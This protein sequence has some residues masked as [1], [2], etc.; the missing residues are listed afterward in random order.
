MK[1]PSCA[2]VLRPELLLP[3]VVLSALQLSATPPVSGPVSQAWAVRI[4]APTN[5][6]LQGGGTTDVSPS[7]DAFVA[8]YVRRTDSTFDIVISRRSPGGILLW[9]RQYEPPDG[10]SSDE[11][12]FGI[13]AHG[14][15]V[16]LTGSIT[17]PT[18]NGHPDFLTLKYRDTG[19]LEWAARFNGPGQY[20]DSA[21]DVTVDAQGNVLVLGESI[22][23][24]RSSDILV[25]KYGPA[26]N[27]LWTYSYDSP[28]HRLERGIG[29][30]LDPA[31]NIYVA[32]TSGESTEGASAIAFKLDPDGHELWTAH[33]TSGSI[34]GIV[35]RTMDLDA[36][37][38]LAISGSERS[39]ALTWKYD[40]NGNRQWMVRYRAEESAAMYPHSVRFD[41]SG[42]L[43][44]AANHY[45]SGINDSVLIKYAATDGRQLWATRF[46]DPGG[47]AHLNALAVDGEGNSYLTTT[48]NLDVITVKVNPSGAQLWTTTF[49]SQGFFYDYGEFLEVLAS[50]DIFVAG[51]STYFSDSYI[52]LIK[53]NQQPV[54]GIATAVVT[55][56]VLVVDPGSNVV[57]TAEATGP[58]PTAYQWR[59]NGRSIPGATHPTLALFDVQPSD[60]GDYS[61]IVFNAAGAT[62]SPESRLSVRTPPQVT[63]VPDDTDAYEGTD[64]AFIATVAGNDFA[65]LQWR[66]NGTNIPG[67]TNEVLRLLNVNAGAS[68]T[69]DIVVSTIGGITTSSTA[70]L[71]FSGAVKLI[72]TTPHRSAP[73]TW[74]YAPQLRVLPSGEFLIAARSNHLDGSTIVLTKHAAHGEPIWATAF[75]SNEFTNA[76][77][78]RM[79]RDGA[80]NIYVTGLSRQPYLPAAVAVL[81]FAPDGLLLWSR[82]LTG[83]NLWNSLPAFS[84]DPSGRSTVAVLGTGET[85]VVR[86]NSAGDL[87]WSFIDPLSADNDTMALAV[88]VSGSAY[89]GT[90]IRV[91]QGADNEVRLRK[92]DANGTTEWVRP[93]ADG[94][95]NR[96]GA[97]AIDSNG[98]LIVAGTGELADTP[99]SW[100]FVQKYSSAGDK[101]WETRTGSS[102]S[103]ITYIVAMATG[104]GDEI[105]VMT[106]SDDDYERGE[107]TGVTRIASDGHLKFRV[108]DPQ[109][110]VF[111]PSQLGLDDFGNAYV[112]GWG[113]GPG[114][115]VDVVTAKYDSS[116][117]RHWLVYF[118]G[119]LWS[120][121]Y[122]LAVGVDAMG[123]IRVLGVTDTG[124]DLEADFN[125]IHYQQWDPESKFRVRIIS[126]TGGTFHLG[127]P[128]GETFRIEASP[129]LRSWRV[130]SEEEAQQLLQP[131]ATAFSAAQQFYRLALS[132]SE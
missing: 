99:D 131:G 21:H 69:Y 76:E 28:D 25:V 101:L 107:L 104:P 127:V 59:K 121:Q 112:T 37:G 93:Y 35:A 52:S 91:N 100:M 42:N 58:Q 80:G 41:T 50:G 118:P 122:G 43:I 105:T 4:Q 26:G 125:V 130:L 124:S 120:W 24:A 9:E 70:G 6:Y 74:D 84:V 53:Y 34:Y 8:R 13:V 87:V 62:V 117:N 68:G 103:E 17:G 98:Q 47:P 39:H 23:L 60:R 46:S 83:T 126:D 11:R 111:T 14:T 27:L 56:A 19:E 3:L 71:R 123:D 63:V 16:Y 116:G 82:I 30:R 7:G 66:H 95:Y 32:G 49:N 10:S 81:K 57:F 22:G 65:T 77:P 90:T 29:I 96:L 5:S 97:L 78:S 89:L 54:S 2:S 113:S 132:N 15:N 12:V 45:G 1:T 109:I 108:A 85:K 94:H 33:E 73:S 129:D 44:A 36:A 110:L 38:N 115:G 48:P 75:E 114:T 92:L 67:A 31:G 128:A 102:W 86:F 40:A 64:V 20:N 61:V 119:P 106:K 72:G 79:A 55:P 18:D 88:D 51:R